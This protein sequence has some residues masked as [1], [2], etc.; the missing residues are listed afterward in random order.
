MNILDRLQ[1]GREQPHIEL[2]NAK[3]FLQHLLTV[4]LAWHLKGASPVK[5][6]NL[7]LQNRLKQQKSFVKPEISSR[8]SLKPSINLDQM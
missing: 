5:C 8:Q 2:L 7:Y 1:Q 6:R 4:E 3:P